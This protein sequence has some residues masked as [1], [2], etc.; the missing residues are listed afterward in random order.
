MHDVKKEI[1]T[2]DPRGTLL[3]T[4]LQPDFV[5]LTTTLWAWQFSLISVHLSG[6]LTGLYFTSLILRMLQEAVESLAQAEMNNIHALL[7]PL[8][9]PCH[10]GRQSGSSSMIFPLE[11]THKN[12]PVLCMLG[13]VCTDY[14][15][16]Q[17]P[18]RQD[19]GDWLWSFLDS[20]SRWEWHL[21]QASPRRLSWPFQGCWMWPWSLSTWWTPRGS[22]GLCLSRGSPVWS[23]STKAKSSLFQTFP[24]IS[25]AWDCSVLNLKQQRPR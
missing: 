8:N 12:V 16:H 4:R 2:N 23:C 11:M 5:P 9:W 24:S 3:V 18:K 13:N 15:L 14:L 1:Q 19:E 25:R 17:H 22:L 7:H 10:H 6:L 21:F 20:L